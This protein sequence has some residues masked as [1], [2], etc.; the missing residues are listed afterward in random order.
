MGYPQLESPEVEGAALVVLQ[1]KR[2]P[3]DVVPVEELVTWW[4]ASAG[5][6]FAIDALL[7]SRRFSLDGVDGSFA[8]LGLAANSTSND[9]ATFEQG[10]A[11]GWAWLQEHLAVCDVPSWAAAR[12]RAAMLRE[13]APLGSRAA[14]AAHAGR[15]RAE[16]DALFVKMAE[17]ERA[18]CDELAPTFP[19]PARALL[20]RRR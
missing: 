10:K 17:R 13:Q 8:N 3:R 2:D 19:E 14:L 20:S 7:A 9:A 1:Q 6:A 12:D 5:P 11:F 15:G 18:L 4:V 16:L